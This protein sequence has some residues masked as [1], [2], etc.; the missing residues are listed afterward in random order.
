[1]SKSAYFAVDN[2]CQLGN[3]NLRSFVLDCHLGEPNVDNMLNLGPM[4]E[5]RNERFA[6][7]YRA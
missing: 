4:W 3:A 1:M 2:P 7:P 6:A 5:E